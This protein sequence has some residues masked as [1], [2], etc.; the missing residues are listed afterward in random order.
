VLLL[1]EIAGI[2]VLFLMFML[3]HLLP[4]VREKADPGFC[5]NGLQ[6]ILRTG[7]FTEQEMEE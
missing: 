6:Q 3:V 1:V 7:V 5:W 2:A 4:R